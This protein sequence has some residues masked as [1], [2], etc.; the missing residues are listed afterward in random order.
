MLNE[1]TPIRK[2]A[3]VSCRFPLV[4][5]PNK[6]GPT[7]RPALI[8][9]VFFDHT[10]NRWKAIVAYGTSQSTR[11]NTG[12]EIRVGA[13]DAL[14]QAGLHRRTRF[15]LSRMRILPL[16]DEFF[17]FGQNGTPVMGY[18]EEPLMDRLTDLCD[19]LVTTSSEL[20]PL[21][22]GAAVMVRSDQSEA[23]DPAVQ[24]N[25]IN[26]KEIDIFFLKS[27]TGRSKG[28]GRRRSHL[29]RA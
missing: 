4:E 10:D 15:V 24:Q 25:D 6:P 19:R 20:R 18:L 17:S 12:F 7:A 27:M 28:S 23:P 13:P 8:V 5:T 22:G 9:R 1:H 2:G 14:Q 3:V 11:S 29:R 21:I 16:D 26:A